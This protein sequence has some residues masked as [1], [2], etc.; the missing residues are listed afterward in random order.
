MTSPAIT[1]TRRR[2]RVVLSLTPLID[3]V[4]ILLVFFMLVSQF[5]Q[6]RAVEMLPEA[7]LGTQLTDQAPKLITVDATGVFTV[8]GRRALTAYNAAELVQASLSP[9]QAV[10]VRPLQGAAIQPV[11]SVVEALT[12]EGIDNVRVDHQGGDR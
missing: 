9:G 10:S 1:L 5:T 8:E 6:W 11:V 7:A 12:S 4:F 2:S 3:V